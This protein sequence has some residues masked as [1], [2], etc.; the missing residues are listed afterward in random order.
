MT[1]TPLMI[2][3]LVFGSIMLLIVG[4]FV[5]ARQ[6]E[7]HRRL[8]QKLNTDAGTAVSAAGPG[9]DFSDL[10]VKAL[11]LRITNS[12]GQLGRPKGEQGRSHIRRMFLKA[13]Y[14]EKN[15][16]VIFWGAKLLCAFM[17][18]ACFFA[19][20]IFLIRNLPS[21]AIVL[22]WVVL[23]II[24]FYLPNLWL[25][26]R[27]SSRR[28]QLLLG[29]PDALDLLVVC[30]EAG[31]GLDAAIKRV[32]DEVKLSSKVISD[33]FKVLNLELRAGKSRR[34]ALKNLALR[35]GLD[36]IN[37]LVTLLIQTDKFG[38]SVAQA[39]RVHSESMRTK[40]AQRVEEMAAKLPVKLLF[41]MIFCIF[42][43]LFLVTIGPA[44]I[45]AFRAWGE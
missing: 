1:L 17:F 38:T 13:G 18:T 3:S 30:A 21:A 43:V 36:D 40:R 14:R 4:L 11:F 44:L 32:G 7:E 23:T 42:P 15:A 9:I 16:L 39:L 20:R 10:T 2:S 41:P 8:V 24:G 25:S 31:M 5:L 6:M 33:E 27:I 26:L 45:Q 34:D 12:L 22:I 37:S 29:F 35:T 19:V 28:E